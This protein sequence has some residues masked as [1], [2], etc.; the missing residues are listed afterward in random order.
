M[1]KISPIFS[2]YI[3]NEVNLFYRIER[4][5]MYKD[6][7]H[8]NCIRYVICWNIQAAVLQMFNK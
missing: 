1:K 6:I 3:Y 5:R 4:W 2:G 7:G 8:G